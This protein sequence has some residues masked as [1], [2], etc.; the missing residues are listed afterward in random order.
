VGIVKSPERLI[1]TKHVDT[2]IYIDFNNR[3]TMKK[4]HVLY[5]LLL[6]IGLIFIYSMNQQKVFLSGGEGTSENPINITNCS[7]LQDMR[8]YLD[9][10]TVYFSLANDI[11][12]NVA[13]YNE[14]EGFEPI[15]DWGGGSFVGTFLGNNR[16]IYNLYIN[17]PSENYVGLFGK[18]YINEADYGR[19][20]DINLV[21]V[22]ITGYEAV[23][24]LVGGGSYAIISGSQVSGSIRG[25]KGVGG[26]AGG[27][28]KITIDNSYVLANVTGEYNIGG[29]VGFGYA[30]TIITNSYASGNITGHH[31]TGGLIGWANP[32]IINNS[33]T[34]SKV[35]GNNTIGGLIGWGIQSTIS[36]SYSSGD[37]NGNGANGGI[38]GLVGQSSQTKIDNSYANGSVTGIQY[39]GGLIGYEFNGTINNS[40]ALGNITGINYIGG[41][42]GQSSQTKIDNSYA[43]GSVTGNPYV[44]GLVGRAYPETI[45]T[46]SY[47][48]GN[49]KGGLY[50]IGG[51]VGYEEQAQII[52]SYATGN[53]TGTSNVGGLIGYEFNATTNNSYSSGA[54]TGTNSVGGLVG[55]GS[56]STISNSY[57][58]GQV[59][60]V[61]SVGGLLGSGNTNPIVN[62]YA[63]GNVNGT[64]NVGGLVGAI[65]QAEIQNS[66]ATGN[67]SGTTL[68]G[69]LIGDG[70]GAAIKNL[71]WNNHSGNPSACIGN[72]DTENCTAIQDNE[73]YFFGVANPPMSAWN[74][75]AIW[76]NVFNSISYPV[77]RWQTGNFEEPPTPPPDNGETPDNGGPSGPS[78]STSTTYSISSYELNRG[79]FNDIK[80]NDKF[81]FPLGNQNHTMTLNSFNETT[82][83][84]TIQSTPIAVYLLKNIKKQIDIN[85]DGILDIELMYGGPIIGSKATIYLGIY[86]EPAGGN[87]QNGT[88]DENNGAADE[89]E[90]DNK[91]KSLSRIWLFSLLI[92]LIGVIILGLIVFYKFRS[93]KSK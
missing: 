63:T 70:T 64:N 92:V 36:N 78:G 81:K 30:E 3:L 43:N 34:T 40:Y 88:T 67:V 39:V 12:C 46:N 85:S 69:G 15:G 22:N 68:I 33:H 51:L 29:L 16:T 21:G 32:A 56:K 28:N 42:V 31:N 79:Y 5:L 1:Q 4:E 6:L 71:Y 66:F 17:R 14:S 38:G 72:V 11:D 41:L 91:D 49:I 8:N 74:F 76:D 86:T 62:S 55:G 90:E 9:N 35:T 19:F 7:E 25:Y 84:V 20:Y 89:N 48:T 87:E 44:G 82:A 73:P 52:N 61:A 65:T 58:L 59:N 13:P 75:A 83:K 80:T 47:A 54:I 2:K 57:A 50:D 24:G 53:V 93:M 45:I 60:G 26:L 10:S 27:G 37:V 77:L 18:A 23:G